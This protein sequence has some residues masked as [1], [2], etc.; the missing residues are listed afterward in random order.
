MSEEERREIASKGG[1]SVPDEKRRFVQGRGPASKAGRK[2][3]NPAA[4]RTRTAC[5]LADRSE[6]DGHQGRLEPAASFSPDR[7]G[8]RS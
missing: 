7:F 8:L 6:F 5:A 2:G 4:R 1:E 3:G